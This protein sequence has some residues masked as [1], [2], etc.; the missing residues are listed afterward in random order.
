MIEDKTPAVEPMN[1]VDAEA[2]FAELQT[3]V[4]TLREA[5]EAYFETMQYHYGSKKDWPADVKVL[6][7]AFSSTAEPGAQR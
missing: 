2:R 1:N 6:A 4:V 7:K 3:E 5:L